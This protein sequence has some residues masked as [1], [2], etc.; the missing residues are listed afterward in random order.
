MACKLYEVVPQCC[1]GWHLDPQAGMSLVKMLRKE[2]Y[3]QEEA[4]KHR[5]VHN[6]SIVCPLVLVVRDHLQAVGS[7]PIWCE[8]CTE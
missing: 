3:I 6:G 7:E 1:R 8:T 2:A 4:S 5:D